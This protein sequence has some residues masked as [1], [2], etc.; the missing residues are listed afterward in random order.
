MLM[1]EIQEELIAVDERDE[2]QERL[3]IMAEASNMSVEE[4]E[5]LII[6]A[7]WDGYQRSISR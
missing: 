5:R 7:A 6:T 1:N 3:R 4:V 2:R